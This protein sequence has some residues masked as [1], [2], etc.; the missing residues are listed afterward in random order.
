LGVKG[1]F[2]RMSQGPLKVKANER[3]QKNIFS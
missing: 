3:Y 1:M 2:A